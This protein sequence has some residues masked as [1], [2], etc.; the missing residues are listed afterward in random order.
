MI[1]G[2]TLDVSI[3]CV[4]TPAQDYPAGCAT[5]SS[6]GTLIPGGQVSVADLAPGKWDVEVSG[7]VNGVAID[8]HQVVTLSSSGTNKTVMASWV[9][10]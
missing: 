4:E 3:K 8:K 6:V 7:T 2:E 1:A 5:A 9:D 10:V